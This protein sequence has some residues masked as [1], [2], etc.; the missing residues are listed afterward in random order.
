MVLALL[1][2]VGLAGCGDDNDGRQASP[3]STVAVPTATQPAPTASEP[4]RTATPEGPTVTRT[5]E[6]PTAT[7]TEPLLGGSP[8]CS[9]DTCEHDHTKLVAIAH[10]SKDT[11][12]TILYRVTVQDRD[13]NEVSTGTDWG[14]GV[15]GFFY[16]VTVDGGAAR[17]YVPFNGIGVGSDNRPTL[18]RF[19]FI[20]PAR[21]GA[22]SIKIEGC[23]ANYP[24]NT[25]RTCAHT[26]FSDEYLNELP[27]PDTA[28]S[29]WEGSAT[30]DFVSS[31]ALA[32]VSNG[33][34]GGPVSFT[35][36]DLQMHQVDLTI[37]ENAEWFR[38]HLVFLDGELNVYTNDIFNEEFGALAIDEA[39]FAPAPGDS[40]FRPKYGPIVS[41]ENK[42]SEPTYF[43]YVKTTSTAPTYAAAKFLFDDATSNGN[44]GGFAALD[45]DSSGGSAGL[46]A[47]N[48][49]GEEPCKTLSPSAAVSNVEVIQEHMAGAQETR[50]ICLTSTGQCFMGSPQG[51]CGRA[52]NPL[53]VNTAEA[54]NLPDYVIDSE[55]GSW[56]AKFPQA[57]YYVVPTG[58]GNCG[59]DNPPFCDQQDNFVGYVPHYADVNGPATDTLNG[60]STRNPLVGGF[61]LA[62]QYA[63][64]PLAS[65]T[66]NRLVW[67]DNCGI[68]QVYFECVSGATGCTGEQGQLGSRKP[69]PSPP[70][71]GKKYTYNITN[72]LPRAIVFGKE[73]CASWYQEE[74]DD[75]GAMH[76][77]PPVQIDDTFGIFVPP[78][79]GQSGEGVEYETVF[80]DEAIVVYDATTGNPLHKLRLNGGDASALYDC[81]NS[82]CS[83]SP[84]ADGCPSAA[85][86][87]TGTDTFKVD[88]GATGQGSIG[89]AP[90]GACPFGTT[91]LFD[92]AVVGC[93][94]SE[95]SFL[96]GVEEWAMEAQKAGAAQSVQLRAW[97][98]KGSPGELVQPARGGFA[99]TVVK[100]EDL[101]NL[102]AYVG[103]GR[104]G[105][106]RLVGG[107]STILTRLPISSFQQSDMVAFTSPRFAD[108]ILLAGGG[109]GTLCG[110]G[111]PCENA[112]ILGG[113]GGVAISN[114]V[115][116][117]GS[118]L[119]AAGGDAISDDSTQPGGGG[120]KD[121]NG[122][123][124]MGAVS[125]ARN[126]MGNSGV[127][128]WGGGGVAW[129]SG[130]L[131]PPPSWPPGQGQNPGNDNSGGGGGGFGGGGRGDDINGGDGG[132]GGSWAAGNT[133]HDPTVPT[134][135][136]TPDFRRGIPGESS[137]NGNS[138]AVQLSY[139]AVNRGV[140][141]RLNCG[142]PEVKATDGGPSWV[143]D[144]RFQ[145]GGGEGTQSTTTSIDLSSPTLRGVTCPPPG[146][147]GVIGGGAPE[148]L[149]Q[150]ER[151]DPSG[152]SEMRFVFPVT[153]GDRIEIRLLSAET[154]PA[155][156]P[157][158][159]VF[160]VR[161]N[162]DAI[163]SDFS[164]IDPTRNGGGVFRGSM[165]SHVLT[166]PS[167]KLTLGFGHITA[168]PTIS[169]IEIRS[170][171]SNVV[172]RGMLVSS[173]EPLHSD[174]VYRSHAGILLTNQNHSLVW[175]SD[176]DLV[177]INPAGLAIWR[178]GTRDA[179]YG[180]NGGERVCFQGDGNFIIYDA[181]GKGLWDTENA[182]EGGLHL[183]LRDDCNL[184]LTNIDGTVQFQT[185]T[186]CSMTPL[187]TFT[188]TPTPTRT[189]TLT[190]TPTITRT[191]THT[192]TI[193][194]TPTP[195]RTAT[196]T[197]TITRTHTHTPTHT[198]TPTFTP[199]STAT[200]TNTA[201]VPP[202]P[203]NT[204]TVTP[205][206]A[207][208]DTP[209]ETPT[210]T[211]T[212]S[213][214]DTA[215]P[216]GTPTVTPTATPTPHTVALLTNELVSTNH[217]EPT[218]CLELPDDNGVILDNNVA[219]LVWQ[220]NGDLVLRQG[221]TMLWQSGTSDDKF[222]GN[223]GR[224][225]CFPN[226]LIIRNGEG[227]ELFSTQTTLEGRTLELDATCNLA[228]LNLSGSILFET[229]TTCAQ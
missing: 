15:N 202:T 68:G 77:V 222:N 184:T 76:L 153:A 40:L 109:G 152:G 171:E 218:D 181:Q 101:G 119:S 80:S 21:V 47:V 176:G 223:G 198:F 52:T 224:E 74:Q 26:V 59:R 116:P 192:P 49:G 136:P 132:G 65:S 123:G 70:N 126:G 159:R 69:L 180:G 6:S 79:R 122:S 93:T 110:H 42:P 170:L 175:Q 221:S 88:L 155:T 143:A 178:S 158:Q 213:A 51:I 11:T 117:P 149:F 108:V 174:C 154:S 133:V 33:V 97:G 27:E 151:Y 118:D 99:F 41:I 75:Q 188:P 209:K 62:D 34:Y 95:S 43:F 199:T 120:N 204:P 86:T 78:H 44:L 38:K 145:D 71:N 84:L 113:V 25:T 35:L 160:S 81:G 141:Y 228:V 195:T 28:G 2:I 138:G 164:D 187:P 148:S 12:G 5:V 111:S 140:L 190:R 56:G 64:P 161:L 46:G 90:V 17:D 173:S 196:A 162:E 32:V 106:T 96:F 139:L 23:A 91:A 1:S 103:V 4:E 82:A 92:G 36:T 18:R 53:A 39:A 22:S 10:S 24:G 125:V 14:D 114:A 13:G 215:T 166:M 150:T 146:Q 229:S 67:F 157:G 115:D 205:T 193:T 191:P 63:L 112:Q 156:Q 48:C 201:T 100:P 214:T 19:S 20:V 203:T 212:P 207:P 128:G 30:L 37:P 189:P 131:I 144:T 177:L 107:S 8:D 3:T 60:G 197:R 50:D 85:I 134:P 227:T 7:P 168:D 105:T 185:N 167:D 61:S 45:G 9:G 130:S 210:A 58:F 104:G 57:L 200:P 135:F 54:M 127:G 217:P 55:N 179:L 169:G 165:V 172:A 182:G 124:G 31:L 226:S 94:A 208:T 73:C 129:S 87:S 186:T 16:Q 225:L 121:G 219:Q 206:P 98:G 216:T 137:P 66:E 89:C 211:P 83:V 72:N 29:P 194:R 163:P 220:T 102:Y 183:T 142:G 147:C